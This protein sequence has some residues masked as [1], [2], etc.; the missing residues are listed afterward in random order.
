M[1]SPHIGYME[2][3]PDGWTYPEVYSVS[4]KSGSIMIVDVQGTE[5]EYCSGTAVLPIF[6]NLFKE[7]YSITISNGGN[8]KFDYKLEISSDWIKVDEIQGNIFHGKIIEVSID[9][10]KVFETSRGCITIL[11]AGEIVK[12]NVTAEVIEV[13]GLP[14]MTSVETHDVISIEA[15]HTANNV[16]R[17]NVEWKVLKNYGRTLS[18]VKMFPTTVSFEKTEEAPYLEYLLRVNEDSEYTL[19]T[20]VAPTNNLYE[21]SRL[22]YAV[23]FDSEAPTIADALP[24]DFFAGSYVNNI[25]CDAVLENIHITS[26]VHKLSKGIHTLR[27][28]GLDAGLVLQKLVLSKGKL[29]YS[30]F[31]PEESFYVGKQ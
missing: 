24:K 6:T 20:Y 14:N 2:W 27:F 9:W 17:S 11:G 5:K 13:G 7:T 12:V 4:P 1:S 18:S 3:S 16:A 28:Y 23:A 21:K 22:K 26:T 25:W 8:A 10:N 19:T 29:P 15:E 30:Y 31:G